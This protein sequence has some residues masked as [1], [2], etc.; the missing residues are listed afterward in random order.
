VIHCSWCVVPDR[1]C[2]YRR[3]TLQCL[4][5]FTLSD[6][7]VPQACSPAAP[8]LHS[9]LRRSISWRHTVSNQLQSLVTALNTLCSCGDCHVVQARSCASSITVSCSSMLINLVGSAQQSVIR[10][11]PGYMPI[12]LR[13]KCSTSCISNI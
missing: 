10:A 4:H 13:M 5:Q 8:P 12:A 3:E 11:C 9:Q 6:F 2:W 1:V 7:D